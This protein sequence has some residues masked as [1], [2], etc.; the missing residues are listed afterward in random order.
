MQQIEA[1]V[2]LFGDFSGLETIFLLR[3]S[4]G[5]KSCPRYG[6]SSRTASWNTR[7]FIR[8]LLDQAHPSSACGPVWSL[9]LFESIQIAGIMPFS[10]TALTGTI[11][12]SATFYRRSFVDLSGP[13]HHV[14]I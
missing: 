3:A 10:Q 7:V 12:P 11:N 6:R 1:Y 2:Y 14:G 9:A 13:S 5:P 4:S 8:V